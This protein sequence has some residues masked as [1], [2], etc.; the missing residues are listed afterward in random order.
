MKWLAQIAY[1]GELNWKVIGEADS[2]VNAMALIDYEIFNKNE[3]DIVK[4][5]VVCLSLP[6]NLTT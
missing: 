1:K 6:E 4:V 2:I 3:E 5:L